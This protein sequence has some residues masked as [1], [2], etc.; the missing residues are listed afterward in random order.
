MQAINLKP[1]QEIVQFIWHV[2][3]L[4]KFEGKLFQVSN[5][6]IQ[7]LLEQLLVTCADGLAQLLL[8]GFG[9][10]NMLT[11]DSDTTNVK[12]VEVV[13]LR[14]QISLLNFREVIRVL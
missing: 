12:L 5:I 4:P 9:Y 1:G 7:R 10:V 14:P 11:F 13:R 6:E 3:Q 8:V 2:I